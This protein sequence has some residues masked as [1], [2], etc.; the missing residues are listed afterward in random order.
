MTSS[1][2]RLCVLLWGWG[3]VFITV[4]CVS[5]SVD[6]CPRFEVFLDGQRKEY[7]LWKCDQRLEVLLTQKNANAK[8]AQSFCA[9]NHAP[10]QFDTFKLDIQKESLSFGHSNWTLKLE[11]SCPGNVKKSY[12]CNPPAGDSELRFRHCSGLSLTKHFSIYFVHLPEAK[13]S[14]LDNEDLHAVVDVPPFRFFHTYFEWRKEGESAQLC[15]FKAEE[16]L[17]PKA[18]PALATLR[19]FDHGP[20]CSFRFDSPHFT[21]R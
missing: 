13:L 14:L 8:G 6:T 5:P 21:F 15:R 16:W 7:F 1:V 2:F 17:E 4:D 11:E 20:G 3:I 9:I 12:F 19:P 18:S 10:L